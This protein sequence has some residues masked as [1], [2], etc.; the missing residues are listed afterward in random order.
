MIRFEAKYDNEADQGREQDKTKYTTA[1]LVSFFVL[2]SK[3]VTPIN[4]VNYPPSF[5][6]YFFIIVLAFR[7]H[8]YILFLLLRILAQTE[9]RINGKI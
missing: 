4:I 8:D 2:F 9:N 3:L 5:V 6:I 7:E 1:F